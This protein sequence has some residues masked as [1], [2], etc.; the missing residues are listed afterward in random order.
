VPQ[1][2]RVFISYV[3]ENLSPVERLVTE[4]RS[5]GADVW[6]D[7][8]ALPP[9]VVWRDEIRRAV[10]RH[11]FFV[12][13]FSHE[14][15]TRVRAYMN[16]ELELAVEEIR[17]RGNVPWF[18][19]VRLSG[20][21]P[22]IR[23]GPTR[24]LRDI[25]YVDLVDKRWASGVDA[26]ARA[27]GLGSTDDEELQSPDGSIASLNFTPTNNVALPHRRSGRPEHLGKGPLPFTLAV[28]L[29]I[30]LV[31]AVGVSLVIS[32]L[33][34]P[35]M[36]EPRVNVEDALLQPDGMRG[37]GNEPLRIA[38]RPAEKDFLLLPVLPPLVDMNGASQF[39][40]ELNALNGSARQLIW[41]RGGVHA[42]SD[43]TLQVLVPGSFL[44]PGNYQLA[45][46][47][48]SANGR[49][50]ARY[51]IRVTTDTSK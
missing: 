4:L 3:R 30:A 11:E 13:C 10:S 48:D 28:S 38:P 36:F 47:R 35:A 44:K 31:M 2:P 23:I 15:N 6:F 51:T 21:I 25:Q 1:H 29:A 12:A 14:Q 16:E 26:I 39:R 46:W 49:E 41:K 42:R 9:G 17:L 27:I 33:R 40:L 8:D 24:T 19:P 5:R 43:G 34:R 37:P 22:D 32:P 50:L 45:V 20:E 18:I 7:Q